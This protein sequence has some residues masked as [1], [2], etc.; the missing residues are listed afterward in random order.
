VKHAD[1]IIV[2]AGL[3]GIGTAVH[4]RRECP[5]RSYIVLEGR[6]AMGGTWDLFRYPGIRSDSDMYT[7]GYDFKPW[8]GRKAIADGASILAYIREA[9]AEY[10]VDQRI[11]YR[12]RVARATWSSADALW[13]LEAADDDTGETTRYTCN[14]LLMCSGYYSYRAGHEPVF[15]GRESFRGT[16]IHPQRWP[17]DLDW[18]GKRV[19][20][21]GSGATAVTLVPVL[22]REAAHVVM[23]QRSPTYVISR[24]AADRVARA[25]NRVLPGRWAYA[26][27]R[28][29]NVRLHDY[30]Y[31]RARS[32]P[33]RVKRFLLGQVRRALGP[34]YDVATH[35]TPSYAPW[36]QRLCLVP[37][38][39]LFDAIRSGAASVVT[40]R[41]DR[42]DEGGIRLVSGGRVDA[43]IVVTATGFELVTPGETE[44][45]V[46][47]V[48]VDF[49]KTWAYR[50]R[51]FS[52]VPNLVYTM[53]YFNASWTLRAD[54]MARWTCR[55]L[56]HMS[57]VGARQATPRLREA[58]RGMTPRPWTGSLKSSYIQRQIASLPR[59]GDREP[60]IVPE[61]YL[62]ERATILREPVEDGVLVFERGPTRR[63]PAAA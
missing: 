56:N 29:K 26:L 3:S 11:R 25:L 59:Q 49:A 23:L 50:G 14:V 16:V 6:A 21:I 2:G 33:G 38:G 19:V 43:D 8:L 20:V 34:D 28:W 7:L 10:G 45:V 46:D 9:A 13:T 24:P 54:L 12:Q 42:F 5:G 40:D 31:R 58:D 41:I 60:W 55:L 48:P 17:A 32:E 39:D 27:V 47:G 35:F 36:D 52:D 53:G 4:L 15:E 57:A 44:F 63:D 1:V 30:I 22:A 62:T 61:R 18:R 51:M 37:D